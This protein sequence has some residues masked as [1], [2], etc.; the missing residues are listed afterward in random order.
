[1]NRIYV[2]PKDVFG[3]GIYRRI[4]LL[5]KNNRWDWAA[6]GATFG[7]I[8]GMLSI[9]LGAMLWAVVPFLAPVS[10]GSFLNGFETLFFILPL[11]S[12]SLGAYCLDLLEKKTPGLPLPANSL[13]ADFKRWLRLRP[14]HPHH[15]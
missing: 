11:P 12:L 15:N 5:I 7:L 8:G 14:R 3:E 13:P 6:I 1:M 9:I 10:L 2:L 4:Y